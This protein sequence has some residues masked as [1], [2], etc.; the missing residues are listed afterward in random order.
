MVVFIFS[1]NVFIYLLI[2]L[3]FMV[4]SKR[5]FLDAACSQ[6]RVT[7]YSISVSFLLLKSHSKQ[8]IIS[9]PPTRISQRSFSHTRASNYLLNAENFIVHSVPNTLQQHSKLPLLLESCRRFSFSSAFAQ[10]VQST[11]VC[12]AEHSSFQ[13]Q[14]YPVISFSPTS[15]T[16]LPLT[17]SPRQTALA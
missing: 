16:P 12:F 5:R 15:L 3:I 6:F 14:G 11:W 13:L 10:F 8:F 7:K 1:I 2:Y 9:P 17:L 4:L